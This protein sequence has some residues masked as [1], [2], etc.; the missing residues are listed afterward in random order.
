MFTKSD[1]NYFAN[2]SRKGLSGNPNITS[3]PHI[4]LDGLK[5]LAK[6]ENCTINDVVIAA[7]SS[8]LHSV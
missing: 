6:V 5:K 1:N 3:G 8:A 2:R 4:E 7:V